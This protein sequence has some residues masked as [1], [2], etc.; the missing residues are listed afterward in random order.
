MPAP[1][2]L[3]LE[4]ESLVTTDPKRRIEEDA[5]RRRSY[6][7]CSS[8]ISQ[9]A[10]IIGDADGIL[11]LCAWLGVRMYCVDQMSSAHLSPAQTQLSQ[12]FQ[13]PQGCYRVG[14]RC[15]K[16]AAVSASRAAS[17]PDQ[18][19]ASYRRCAARISPQSQRMLGACTASF[20]ADF[21]IEAQ[22]PEMDSVER[23][24]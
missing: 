2:I 17:P 8:T 20:R 5:T 19:S 18:L 13:Q 10:E 16:G 9:V 3:K 24:S 21:M 15:P 4:N 14:Y 22:R 7:Q 1:G 23:T 11:V 12:E 6:H